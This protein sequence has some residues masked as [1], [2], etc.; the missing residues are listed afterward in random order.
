MIKAVAL[1]LVVSSVFG[2]YSNIPEKDTLRVI[3]DAKGGLDI[4]AEKLPLPL[5]L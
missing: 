2:S 3:E 4:S 5:T 1:A